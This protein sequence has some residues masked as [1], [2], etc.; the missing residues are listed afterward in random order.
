MDSMLIK[1][2]AGPEMEEVVGVLD[3][4][5]SQNQN[6]LDKREQSAKA[7]IQK[8]WRD[9]VYTLQRRPKR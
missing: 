6:G 7:G 3:E 5:Q 8:C 1:S 9:T 2:I 4:S